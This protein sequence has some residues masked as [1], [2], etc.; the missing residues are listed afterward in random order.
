MKTDLPP[1]ICDYLCR[2]SLA[3]RRP[4]YLH[5]DRGGHIRDGGGHL[6]DYDLDPLE[7]GR[8]V[9][10]VLD[11]MEGLLPLDDDACHLGCLQPQADVCIDAHIIPDDQTYWLLLLDTHE[12]ERR[13][14]ALQQKANE[15]ALLREAQ[16]RLLRRRINATAADIPA[17]TFDPEGERRQI[18]VLAVGLR[19]A[20]GME[21]G[22]PPP[23]LLDSLTRFR[24][25]MA[26][27]L[28]AGGGL[29]YVQTSD[30]LMT[31]FGLLPAQTTPSEQGLSAALGL[32][33]EFRSRDEGRGA[34]SRGILPPAIG[35]ASGLSVVGI[36]DASP[37]FRLRAVGAPLRAAPHLMQTAVPGQILID[38]GSFQSAGRLQGQFAPLGREQTPLG[39]PVY[40]YQRMPGA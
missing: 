28:Q 35:V 3:G 19:L 6:T 27:G 31:L 4:V 8:P 36:G 25:K 33:D 15:L 21:T 38:R 23:V 29:D 10:A 39:E 32:L 40:M 30:S 9:A 17:V 18:T 24:R 7:V 37:G 26:G 34:A 22:T 13:Q 5:L 11:F 14:R 20:P 16:A 2:Q 1:I 12:D